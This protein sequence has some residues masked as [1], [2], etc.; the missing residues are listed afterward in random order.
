MFTRTIAASVL[1]L[2]LLVPV[3]ASTQSMA[4]EPNYA[5]SQ[6]TNQRAD[7]GDCDVKST[8]NGS[9][10]FSAATSASGPKDSI[11]DFI[12]ETAVEKN[13]RSGNN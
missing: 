5:C 2:G 10:A 11:G 4:A 8:N 6:D 7:Y 9:A 12:D 3:I 13:Q 1:A